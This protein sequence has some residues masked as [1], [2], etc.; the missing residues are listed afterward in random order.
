MTNNSDVSTKIKKRFCKD[1]SVPVNVFEEP[2]FSERIELL[3]FTDKFE[4][5]KL[6]IAERFDNDEQKFFQYYNELQ[7]DIIDYIKGSLTY[8]NFIEENIN[9]YAMYVVLDVTKG[10]IYDDRY[11][12]KKFISIDMV[13]ANISALVHYSLNNDRE[14][15]KFNDGLYDYKH[16]IRKFTDIDYF[17]ESK[18]L[19]QV[20]FGNCN[21]KR[22]ITYEKCLMSLVYVTIQ[23]EFSEITD[24]VVA[25]HNDEII[26]DATDIDALDKL[27]DI[28]NVVSNTKIPLRTEYFK[29]GKVSG[30]G[31]FIKHNL[32][33]GEKELKCNNPVETVF[34]SRNMHNQE[35]I[36]DDYVISTQYGLA[37]LLDKPDIEV[38]FEFRD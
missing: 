3:G 7:D 23:R 5:L 18:Y 38:D 13:K 11:I 28:V 8:N 31:V 22:Q 26:I 9:N 6:L 15:E 35:I 36:D 14:K 25:F 4:E 17:A 1:F 16:F 33:T 2:Y 10:D 19:R 32:I 20:I 34:V 12:S 30:T 37:K 24:K 21:S 29:L 27:R